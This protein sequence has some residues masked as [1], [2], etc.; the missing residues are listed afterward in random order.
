VFF[1]EFRG[2]SKSEEVQTEKDLEKVRFE[3]RDDE[4]DS[5][6]SPELDEKVEQLTPVV[7]R[8]N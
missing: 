6:E 1:R 5:D 2:N 8:Y 4:D 7:R 3:L